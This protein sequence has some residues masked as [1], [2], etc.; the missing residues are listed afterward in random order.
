MTLQEQNT[1]MARGAER[2]GA[3]AAIAPMETSPGDKRPPLP[4]H[5]NAWW[6]HG[7][8]PDIASLKFRHPYHYKLECDDSNGGF[9]VLPSLPSGPMVLRP[10]HRCQ[11]RRCGDCDFY[12]E[13]CQGNRYMVHQY[14]PASWDKEWVCKECH[15]CECLPF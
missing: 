7:I 13:V 3:P 4:L 1:T 5:I 14:K 11:C 10:V 9:P 8:P 12:V 15:I 6:P 2:D